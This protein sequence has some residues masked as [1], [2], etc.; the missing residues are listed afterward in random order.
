[1]SYQDTLRGSLTPQYSTDTSYPTGLK[2]AHIINVLTF[3]QPPTWVDLA[4]GHFI[5]KSLVPLNI[6]ARPSPKMLDPVGIQNFLGSPGAKRGTQ[7]FK[8]GIAWGKAPR[9]QV[10]GKITPTRCERQVDPV[11]LT[12]FYRFPGH[13]IMG[14][15]H[16][17]KVLRGYLKKMLSLFGIPQ[18][19]SNKFNRAKQVL[20]G[21]RLLWTRRFKLITPTWRVRQVGKS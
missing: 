19:P 8:A 18:E 7:L 13:F 12:W 2:T 16:K 5:V 1:M 6:Y 15:I 3:S 11:L 10:V 9:D 21:G 4:Q 20:S 17:S 14:T